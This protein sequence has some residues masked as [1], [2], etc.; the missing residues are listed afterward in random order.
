MANDSPLLTHPHSS[1]WTSDAPFL[2]DQC[3][4]P[5]LLPTGT[6]LLS[7]SVFIVSGARQALDSVVQGKN[8]LGSPEEI[9]SRDC[10][11]H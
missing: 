6:T 9:F 11:A 4:C 1:A 5:H 8:T 2:S 10:S 3:L 7:T